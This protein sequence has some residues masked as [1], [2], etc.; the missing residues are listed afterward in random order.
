MNIINIL[1]LTYDVTLYTP[2]GQTEKKWLKVRQLN[3]VF[4]P[5]Q[6][7]ISLCCMRTQVYVLITFTGQHGP[8]YPC[9]QGTTI[10]TINSNPAGPLHFP[11]SSLASLL[12][13]RRGLLLLLVGPLHFQ[14]L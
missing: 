9:H 11:L 3:F 6:F 13:P 10:A 14:L 4:A 1:N 7:L 8:P 2:N 5:P 12:A